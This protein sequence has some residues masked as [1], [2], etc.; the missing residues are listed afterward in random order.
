MHGRFPAHEDVTHAMKL[1]AAKLKQHPILTALGALVI[2]VALLAVFWDWNW[3]NPLVAGTI[4]KELDRSVT[5]G[6]FDVK[7]ILSGSPLIVLDGVSIGN[8]PDFP[9]G[10]QLGTIGRLSVRFDGSALLKSRGRDVVLHDVVVEHPEGDLRAGPKGNRNWAFDLPSGGNSGSPP[11]IGSLVITEGNFHF[12]DPK[13]KADLA[14]KIHTDPPRDGGEARL[15]ATAQGTYAGQPFDGHFTGGSLL[16]LRDPSKPYPVDL[17]ATDGG[18]KIV[19]KGTIEDPAHLAGADLQ[20]EVTGQDLAALYPIL[21][22]PLAETPPYDLRGHLDY[23]GNHIKFSNFAGTVGQSDLEGN[24]DVDRSHERPLITADIASR[25]VL[26][27][28]LGGFIGTVPG[29]AGASGQES[30]QQ[31]AERAQRAASPNLLP[32]EPLDLGKLRAAD[33]RVHYKGRQIVADWAPLDN[34]EANLTIDN[35]KV[36]LQPLNF[37]VGQGTIASALVLDAGKNPIRAAA[38]IDFRR[39]DFQRLMQA[40]KRFDGV[41]VIG[42]SAHI[43]GDGNSLAS[44]LAHGNGALTLFMNGGNISALVVNLAGLDFGRSILSALGLPKQADIR[45]MVSDFALEQGVLQTRALVF[46]TDEANILGT[47]TVDL[48]NE[49]LDY[50]ITQEPKHFSIGAVHAPI[51]VTGAM[52]NPDIKPDPLQLGA[53]LGAAAALGIAF[54]PAA[55]LPTIQLGLGRDNNCGALLQAT[56]QTAEIPQDAPKESQS[57]LRHQQ[58]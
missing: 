40:T 54:P 55:L 23:S 50:R 5:I 36:T 16:A 4:A 21:G 44:M 38:Q 26:L 24:F 7:D 22:L 42:G 33:F 52:K 13:L 8:P 17:V 19:L 57:A 45:C 2:G 34:L 9:E 32:D 12:D 37:G 58:R 53:R 49:T 31:Q 35:G 28:D 41:G 30:N 39:V 51:D 43:E 25:K 6:R 47:G 20:L 56:Q 46:D 18:T 29:A 3:F 1:E 14:I 11:R 10:S 48:R 27:T 15:V